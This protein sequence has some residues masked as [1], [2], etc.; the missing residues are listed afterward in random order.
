MVD[1]HVG[2]ILPVHDQSGKGEQLRRP[3]RSRKRA[4]RERRRNRS[5]RRRSMR[6]GVVVTL[7]I[8]AD[9]RKSV[10]RRKGGAG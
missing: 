4:L 10:D 6:D 5:D 9:R 8:R 7:S 3:V 2:N 1:I